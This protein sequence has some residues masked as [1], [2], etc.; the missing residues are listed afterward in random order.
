MIT[1]MGTCR[2][3]PLPGANDLHQRLTFTHS[4]KEV[5]QLISF[6]NGNVEEMKELPGECFRAVIR[7]G[8]TVEWSAELTKTWNRSDTVLVELCS[9]KTYLFRTFYLHHLCVDKRFRYWTQTDPRI[10]NEYC[11]RH[12]TDGE[13][14]DDMIQIVERCHPRR[15]I[16]VTHYNYPH[17]SIHGRDELIQLVKTISVK[18]QFECID[19]TE[20]LSAYEPSEVMTDD[21]GHYTAF[22][23]RVWIEKLHNMI[24]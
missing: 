22:G 12:Q 2:I 5:L 16:F 23:E 19:P 9:R 14:E 13:I 15:V 24:I 4:T 11:L 21:G 10:L 7:D 18:H 6:L 3:A 1:L 17:P 20:V 8:A